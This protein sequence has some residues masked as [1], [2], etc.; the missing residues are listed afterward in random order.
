MLPQLSVK[1]SYLKNR[2]FVSRFVISWFY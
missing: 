2:N 1:I